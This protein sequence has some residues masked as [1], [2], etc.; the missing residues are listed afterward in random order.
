MIDAGKLEDVFTGCLKD[1]VAL[2]RGAS[3]TDAVIIEGVINTFGFHPQRLEA[4]RPQVL[5]WLHELPEAFLESKGG[6]WSFLNACV[7]RSGR[8]WGEHRNIEQLL[9]L[10]IGLGLA[11]IQFPRELWSALPGGMPYFVVLDKGG[12]H[13]DH[14]GEVRADR[15]GGL[16]RWLRGRER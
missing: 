13:E 2:E 4:T 6:G 3:D 11:K 9:V 8:Q 16:G 15:G 5:E 1:G 7:D 10:G 14:E 12:N